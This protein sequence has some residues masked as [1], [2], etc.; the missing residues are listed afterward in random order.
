MNTNYSLTFATQKQIYV[1][2]NLQEQLLEILRSELKDNIQYK[3]DL[4]GNNGFV[5]AVIKTL[6]ELIKKVG[7]SEY[8]IDYQ[9]MFL[10]EKINPYANTKVNLDD[11][12]NW[13]LECTFIDDYVYTNVEW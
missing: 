1:L 4:K 10:R 2:Q 5:K 8:Y 11:I 9:N 3:K 6:R 7:S 13:E 12:F